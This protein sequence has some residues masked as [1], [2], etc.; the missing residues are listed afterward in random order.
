MLRI[1]LLR[2]EIL[3]GERINVVCKPKCFLNCDQ[4]LIELRNTGLE[5]NW[6]GENEAHNTAPRWNGLDMYL[7]CTH[8]LHLT[9]EHSSV[10]SNIF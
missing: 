7:I 4:I 2:T 10:Q 6:L 9:G 8:N 1:L 3:K 5:E